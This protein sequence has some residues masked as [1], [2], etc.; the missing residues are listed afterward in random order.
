MPSFRS[1][2]FQPRTVPTANVSR[3]GT[4]RRLREEFQD[5]E[6]EQVNPLVNS[7]AP[8]SDLNTF[9]QDRQN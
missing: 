6:L 1:N 3:S 4:L 2:Y 8:I 9:Q 7:S 5:M